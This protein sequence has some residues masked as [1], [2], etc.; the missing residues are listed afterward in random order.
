MTDMKKEGATLYVIMLMVLLV[1]ALFM[2]ETNRRTLMKFEAE[3]VKNGYGTFVPG[4]SNRPE[5]QWNKP[6]SKEK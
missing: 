3:A 1:I 5:F 2:L 6:S 4:E